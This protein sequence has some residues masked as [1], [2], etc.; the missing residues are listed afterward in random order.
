[1]GESQGKIGGFKSLI[2]KL[3]IVRGKEFSSVSALERISGAGNKTLRDAYN[4]DRFPKEET[5]GKLLG[6]LG[7]TFQQF[8]A[9]IFRN[10]DQKDDLIDSLKSQL[11]DKKLIITLLQQRLEDCQKNISVPS[12]PVAKPSKV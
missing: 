10:T 2:D 6:I 9:G 4:E 8:E 7:V 3:L 12:L 5:M 11:E 1:M